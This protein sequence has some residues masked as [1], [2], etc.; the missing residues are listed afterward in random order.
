MRQPDRRGDLSSLITERLD[1]L[2]LAWRSAAQAD[3]VAVMHITGLG[4]PAL[5]D[6]AR[7]LASD[8]VKRPLS[9]VVE[10]PLWIQGEGR[11]DSPTV[12]LASLAMTLRDMASGDPGLTRAVDKAVLELANGLD[13]QKRRRIHILEQRIA[14]DTLT[15]ADS[16][17]TILRTLRVE[18]ARSVRY[19][20]PLSVVYIDVDHLK[21]VNDEQG[22]S[23]GDELL[24]FLTKIVNQNK[25]ASD[26]FGRLGGDEFLLVLPETDLAGAEVVAT[27]MTDLLSKSGIDV[28]AGVTDS[29]EVGAEPEALV[30]AADAAMR[31]AKSRR[32]Q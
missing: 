3:D 14:T 10:S 32:D 22:H 17:E 26:A 5:S 6:I 28:S 9:M 1:E 7:A 19:A 24:T 15:G 8:P 29:Q 18:A 27:K 13:S 16:R 11:A 2:R 31:V 30:E 4:K 12:L 20:R 23:A 21:Q 25:R